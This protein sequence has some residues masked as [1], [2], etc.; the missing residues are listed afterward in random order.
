ML[1]SEKSIK[2]IYVQKLSNQLCA[3]NINKFYEGKKTLVGR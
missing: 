2:V 3:I 1:N